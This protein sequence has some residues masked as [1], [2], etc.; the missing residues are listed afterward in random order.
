MEL[1]RKNIVSIFCGVVSLLAIVALYWPVGSYYREL[2]RKADERKNAYQSLKGIL[3]RQRFKPI[4]KLQE[5]APEPLDMFPTQAVIDK[6]KAVMEQIRRESA[7]VFQTAVQLNEHQPLVPGS[8]PHGRTTHAI[9]FRRK[10]NLAMD[11]KLDEARA[12]SYLLKMMRAGLRPSELEIQAETKRV[13]ESIRSKTAYGPNNQPLNSA[14]IEAELAQELPKVADRLKRSVAEKCQVYVDDT[15]LDPY[16]LL[17]GSGPGVPPE[18]SIIYVA[19]VGLWIHEDVARSIA[20]ANKGARN[21][22]ESAVKHVVKIDLPETLF[23]PMSISPDAGAAPPNP[24]PSAK[25]PQN[26]AASPTGRVSNGVYDVI[27]FALQLYVDAERVPQVLQELARNKFLTVTTCS[28]SS[29]DTGLA[30]ASGYYYGDKPVVSLDLQCEA[31]LLRK[32]TEPLMP[33]G[34]KQALGLAPGPQTNIPQ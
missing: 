7:Q 32:W 25:L 34:I 9:E 31:L 3:D 24:D 17:I 26:F 2:Q 12:E 30:Q 18:P 21:V 1:L 10:Y 27:P 14:Q 19:Q 15:S 13:E 29:V 28:L 11:L 33:L 23:Q 6:G 5:T 8:L 22:T 20:A 4:I 16:Q